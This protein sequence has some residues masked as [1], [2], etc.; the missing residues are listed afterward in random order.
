VTIHPDD[1][2]LARGRIAQISI[3]NQLPGRVVRVTDGPSRVF[4]EIDVGFPLLACITRQAAS[5]I[6]VA[7]GR[8]VWCLIK[9]SA[10]RIEGGA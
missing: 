2:A 7:P 1:I 8:E 4:A 6:E 10:V 5:A 3:Q 9:A